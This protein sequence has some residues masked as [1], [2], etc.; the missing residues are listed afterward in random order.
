MSTIR[1]SVNTVDSD[2]WP[3][4]FAAA[5]VVTVTPG[6]QDSGHC[7]FAVEV[8]TT[9]QAAFE[10]ALEADAAVIAYTVVD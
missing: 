4:A 10:A 2:S 7:R 5:G 3:V 6:A 9:A 1:Y 8:N